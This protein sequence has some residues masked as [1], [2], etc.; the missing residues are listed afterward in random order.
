[1]KI[2]LLGVGKQGKAALTDLMN[3]PQ[4]ES[5]IAADCDL[6]QLQKFVNTNEGQDRVTCERFDAD[7]P[8]DLDR[9]L[10]L[11]PDVIIDLLPRHFLMSVVKAACVA[12][13][14]LVNTL[15]VT[16]ELRE[17]ASIAEQNGIAML[18]EFG[19][20]PG[21]DLVMLGD[22]VKYLDEVTEVAAY[23][24]GI[25]VEEAADNPLKY[26]VS[27]TLEG[28]L[29]AY[30]RPAKGIS[31][32][33]VIEL[34]P[35]QIFSTKFMREI[36]IP[37]VGVLEAYPN[38]SSLDVADTLGLDHSTLKSCWRYTMRWPGHCEFWKKLF[39]RISG[40]D[41]RPA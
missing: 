10:S 17:Y 5:V 25:P 8:L 40:M 39:G 37:E 31:D 13:V 7:N 1:V 4:V 23:G 19:L 14:H 21:I 27:W 15:F 20:D 22:A 32:G 16:D 34:T 24:A 41:I 11:Q 2:L 29:N 33:K 36:R 35:S 38:G 12:R 3:S 26:K 6:D 18:P 30:R 9:L 28:V